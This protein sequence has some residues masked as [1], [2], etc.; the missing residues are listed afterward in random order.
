[1]NIGFFLFIGF[2][3]HLNKTRLHHHLQKCELPHNIVK[4]DKKPSNHELMD[5]TKKTFRYNKGGYDERPLNTTIDGSIEKIYHDLVKLDLLKILQSD[6]VS[7]CYKIM[8]IEEYTK[9]NMHSIYAPDLK[10][11]GLFK[12]WDQ[13]NDW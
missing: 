13:G 11:G 8:A 7:E 6:T 4:G 5:I 12:D 2:F 1:M 9:N 3:Q 10:A